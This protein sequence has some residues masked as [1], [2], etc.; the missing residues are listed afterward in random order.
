[1]NRITFLRKELYLSQLELAQA[2]G[3]PRYKLQILEQNVQCPTVD[4]AVK[5][6]A[7]LGVEPMELLSVRGDK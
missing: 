6:A 2:S 5:L 7:I 3:I 1:M 4:E